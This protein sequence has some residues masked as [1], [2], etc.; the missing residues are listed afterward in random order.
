M[1]AGSQHSTPQKKHLATNKL[2]SPRK[3][4]SMFATDEEDHNPTLTDLSRVDE[5]TVLPVS[6]DTSRNDLDT[7]D[8][9]HT[10]ITS[11]VIKVRLL[12]E[13]VKPD[14]SRKSLVPGLGNAPKCLTTR[15]IAAHHFMHTLC[16]I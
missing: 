1:D 9:S 16:M 8:K 5:I 14:S 7:G 15:F 12:L 13:T 3:R 11:T 4:F 10:L 6:N 2:D